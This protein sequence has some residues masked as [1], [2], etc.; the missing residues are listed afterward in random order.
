MAKSLVQL[1]QFTCIKSALLFV[2]SKTSIP[3][4]AWSQTDPRSLAPA[5]F[6]H[7][8]QVHTG[9][10]GQQSIYATLWICHFTRW[11]ATLCA[12]PSGYVPLHFR[13]NVLQQNQTAVLHSSVPMLNVRPKDK[14]CFYHRGIKAISTENTLQILTTIKTTKS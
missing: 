1:P 4:P 8:L 11:T 2:F 3:F 14:T 12:A 6:A 7:T 13:K 9:S 10:P 5:A